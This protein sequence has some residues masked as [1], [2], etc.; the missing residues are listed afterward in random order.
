VGVSD[1]PEGLVC[2]PIPST[3]GSGYGTL[4]APFRLGRSAPVRTR[5]FFDGKR[6]F[7]LDRVTFEPA[8]D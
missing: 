7:R 5:V 3:A 1:A 8:G 6:E 2:E 4:R